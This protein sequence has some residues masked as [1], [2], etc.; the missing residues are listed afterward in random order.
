MRLKI[1]AILFA[2][3]AALCLTTAQPAAKSVRLPLCDGFDFPVGP[4]DGKG[5]Y[6]ARGFWPHGHLGDDW[7]GVGGG[8]SDLGDPVY[9][10]AAGVVTL[11]GNMRKGWGNTVIIRHAYR[12]RAT[13]RI[14]FIDSF[15]THLDAINT[16]LGTFVKKGQRIGTIGSNSGMYPAHLH[17]EIRK[18]INIGL[19][20][21]KHAQDYSNYFSPVH[22]IKANRQLA[23]ER[24][25]VVVPVDNYE[26]YN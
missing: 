22:F 1:S 16:K 10:I 26:P 21:M 3:A 6:M 17:L 23:K 8:N 7:N 20:R 12:D 19:H 4:P 14:A 2:L 18:N 5:Y 24:G 9:S 11:A 15:Y 13:G 25:S